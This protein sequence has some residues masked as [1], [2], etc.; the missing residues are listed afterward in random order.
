MTHLGVEPNWLLPATSEVVYCRRQYI[1]H[2]RA[3]EQR[4]TLRVEE[5]LD[6]EIK[7]DRNWGAAIIE[8]S[9][10]IGVA[11]VLHLYVPV[12]G[13]IETFDVCPVVDG[14]R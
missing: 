10:S 12:P 4:A 1:R 11:F 2:A 7:R 8:G 9:V 5:R 14:L 13:P 6:V 3:C